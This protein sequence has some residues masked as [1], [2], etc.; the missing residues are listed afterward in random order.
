MVLAMAEISSR[1]IRLLAISSAGGHWEQLMLLREAFD[2]FEVTYANPMPGLA[3]RSGLGQALRIP[4]F[5]A[6]QPLKMLISIVP[7]FLLIRRVRP[8]LVISTGAAP[9][10]VALVLGKLLRIRTIWVDSVANSER[11]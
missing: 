5:N 6:N 9:G 7:L 2:G 10:L 1:Q 3:E 11:L 4:D 8:T